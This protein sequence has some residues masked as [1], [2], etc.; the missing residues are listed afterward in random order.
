[1]KKRLGVKLEVARFLQDTVAEMARDMKR[2]RTG[3]VAATA[4][5][6]YNFINKARVGVVQ[7]DARTV[8]GW[9]LLGG[10]GL[11]F[12]GCFL[13]FV[14]KFHRL[15]PSLPPHPPPRQ[16]RCAPARRWTTR[17]SSASRRCSTTS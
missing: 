15:T 16:N 1:M 11:V 14:R 9:L 12:Q 10:L 17:S 13:G 4:D 3:D 8:R 6:L 2:S 7:Y 5:E